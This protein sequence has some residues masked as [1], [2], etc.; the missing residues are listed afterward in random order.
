MAFTFQRRSHLQESKMNV[1]KCVLQSHIATEHSVPT[2][3]EVAREQTGLMCTQSWAVS[4]EKSGVLDKFQ[5]V[6]LGCPR[7]WTRIKR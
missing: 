3:H 4:L 5:D 7:S 6:H 2:H 1:T